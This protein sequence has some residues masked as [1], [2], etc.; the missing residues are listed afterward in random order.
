MQVLVKGNLPEGQLALM[1][2]LWSRTA[3]ARP[4]RDS[5]PSLLTS[6]CALTSPLITSPL[7]I[8]PFGNGISDPFLI[9][10]SATQAMVKI[11]QT[12]A[13]SPRWEKTHKEIPFPRKGCPPGTGAFVELLVGIYIRNHLERIPELSPFCIV[14]R[15]AYAQMGHPAFSGKIQKPKFDSPVPSIRGTGIIEEFITDCNPISEETLDLLHPLALEFMA[16]MDILV[17]NN[18]RTFFNV[19]AKAGAN[20]NAAVLI[21]H[22]YALS[23]EGIDGGKFCWLKSRHLQSP[24]SPRMQEFVASLDENELANL[25]RSLSTELEQSLGDNQKEEIQNIGIERILPHKIALS[26]LKEAILQNW[27]LPQ[28]G[29][30]LL[31]VPRGEQ[32]GCLAYEIY[33]KLDPAIATTEDGNTLMRE[34]CLKA[35]ANGPATPL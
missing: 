35:I 31:H 3:V 29:Y 25:A 8:R 24:L 15:I 26:F 18:D 28:I 34:L 33:K 13:G 11:R 7:T 1:Q 19:L 5:S 12:E 21:D 22:G 20:G 4:R 27:T 14:P 17:L 16:I 2:N 10:I 32:K 9:S 6:P 30:T 23:Q